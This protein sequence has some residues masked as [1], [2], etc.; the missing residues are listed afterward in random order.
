MALSDLAR[1][2]LG[3]GLCKTA[4]GEEI[5]DAIDAATERSVQTLSYQ[6]AALAAGADLSEVIIGGFPRGAVISRVAF[7]AS[8]GFGTVDETNTAVFRLRT[9]SD[10]IVTK[11]FDDEDLPTASAI[12]D[13][14]TPDPDHSTLA[15]D[16]TIALTITNGAT[17]A[18]P[19]G[20]LIVEYTVPV[21]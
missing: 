7:V 17:A 18:T 13:L 3:I 5:A 12:N 4:V 15:A 20:Q 21:A 14:G 10:T 1:R 19:T 11:T 16:D 2:L 9:G 6:V 8:G